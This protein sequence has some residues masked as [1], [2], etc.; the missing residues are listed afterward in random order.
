MAAAT[1]H[2]TIASPI[3]SHFSGE[4]TEV[5]LPG[6]D[7]VFQ[8]LAHHEPLVTTLKK[9]TVSYVS[10]GVEHTVDIQGGV[11]EVAENRCTVLL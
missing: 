1:F 11:V 4:A 3:Q 7:G 2:L 8:V 5:S 6:I 10:N 9:G